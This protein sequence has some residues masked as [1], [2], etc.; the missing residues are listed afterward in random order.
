MNDYRYD[1]FYVHIYRNNQNQLNTFMHFMV[2][3]ALSV[4]PC[5][6]SGCREKHSIELLDTQFYVCLYVVR[7][8]Y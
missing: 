6:C 4:A 7:F 2:L 3:L 8:F 5:V 1:E